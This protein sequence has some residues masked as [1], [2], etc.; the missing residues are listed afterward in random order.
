MHV[1]TN[2]NVLVI[3]GKNRGKSGKV[4]RVLPERNRVVVEGVNLVKRH[5]KQRTPGGPSG[6][7]ERE[8]PLHASNVMLLCPQC[9]RP[10]RIGHKVEDGKKRRACK[11]CGTT[12]E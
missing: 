3:A 9:N 11:R 6:I 2:D 8:A 7:I 1:K 5:M 4:L 12:I 10:T